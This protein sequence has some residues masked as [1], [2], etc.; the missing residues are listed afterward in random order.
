MGVCL[1]HPKIS[2][3]AWGAGAGCGELRSLCRDSGS[4]PR[5]MGA[6]GGVSTG[7]KQPQWCFSR[8]SPAVPWRRHPWGPEWNQGG[9]WEEE[10]GLWVMV[11]RI[12]DGL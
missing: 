6:M 9:G 5:K 7:E 10:S 11:A 3:E 1:G 2:K 4:N 12:R 8:L